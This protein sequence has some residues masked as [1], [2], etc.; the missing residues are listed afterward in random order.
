M[1]K[2]VWKVSHSCN[3]DKSIS[4]RRRP[5]LSRLF[6]PRVIPPAISENFRRRGKKN[7]GFKLAALQSVTFCLLCSPLGECSHEECTRVQSRSRLAI[8]TIR[9]PIMIYLSFLKLAKYASR[10]SGHDEKFTSRISG[11]TRCRTRI[12][13]R[14]TDDEK[15]TDE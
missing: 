13:S 5:F 8:P 12:P 11:R 1:L 6:I 15:P 2:T 3:S 4:V 9:R 14:F 7:F 10:G